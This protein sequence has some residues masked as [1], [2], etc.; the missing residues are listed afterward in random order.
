[1]AWASYKRLSLGHFHNLPQVHHHDSMA[2]VFNHRQ[3]V[4]DKQQRQAEA[5]LQILQQVHNLRLDRNIESAHWLIADQ[6]PR[7][8]RQGAGDAN[9]LPLSPAKF[10]R[11]PRKSAGRIQ[12]DRLQQGRYAFPAAS[13]VPLQVVNLEGFRHNTLGRQPRVQRSVR[14]LEN[15]LKPAALSPQV[16]PMPPGNF[17][18]IEENPPAGGFNKSGDGATQR[19]FATSA[20]PDQSQSFSGC[21]REFNRVHGSHPGSCGAKESGLDRE[22]NL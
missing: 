13:P 15:H 8:K 19:G 1:V 4:C 22:M 5:F 2:Y 7:I 12:S 3:V 21:D 11:I 6:Q 18:P 14:I 20:F 9:P 16:G 17:L 10:V